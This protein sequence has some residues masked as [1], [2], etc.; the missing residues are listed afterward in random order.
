MI[1]VE[2]TVLKR[3]LIKLFSRINP[4]SSTIPSP[5]RSITKTGQN[6]TIHVKIRVL[7]SAEGESLKPLWGKEHKI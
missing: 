7:F 6:D 5:K 1:T 3:L 2:S 4:V